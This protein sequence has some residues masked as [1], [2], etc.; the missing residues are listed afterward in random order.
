MATLIGVV[1]QVIGEV[2]AVAGDGSR[3]PLT[4][5]DRVYAGEQL[6]TGATGAVAVTM[7]NGQQ[8]TLGRDS[9]L[10]LSEQLLA[11]SADGNT[12]APQSAADAPSAADLSDVEQ[13]QAA[14]EAGVDP[15]IEGEATAA[16][17]GAGGGAGGAGG[18]G[19][20]FVLLDEVGGALEPVIGFPTE[21]LGTGPEFPDPDPLVTDETPPAPDSTPEIEVEYQD[22]SGTVI[23]GPAVVD[24]EALG[25]GSN[26]GSNAEQASGTLIINS[27]D[28]VSAVEIQD[29]NGVW[30]DVTAGGVVQG[31]YG[32]LTVDAAGN[33]T[34]TLTDNTLDHS[35]P[36]AT[37]AADQVG[38]S[39]L[40]RMF[41]LDGDVSPTVSLDVLVNDD[42]PGAGLSE[43]AP[44]LGSA[45][46]D[47]S[48]PAF[49]GVGGDGVAS[50]VLSAA[51]VQAQ[52]DSAYGADGPGTTAYSLVLNGDD[53]PS[54]LFA[55]DAGAPGG[56]GAEIVLNQVGNV[57]TGSAGGVDYFTLTIDPAT[58]E[59][60]LQLLDNIWHADTT[61]HDDAQT[62]LL[63]AG[64]LQLVQTVI[65]GDGDRASV[66]IDLGAVGAFRFEDDGPTLTV[67]A[68][69]SQAEQA[70]LAVRVDETE[71]ADR[72]APGET[73][74]GN[75]DGD[76]PG[77]GR[78]TTTV[79]G[80]LVNLFAALGGDH[81]SDGPGSD[82]GTFSFVG[83]PAGGTLATNLQAIDGGAIS[84]VQSSA[85]LL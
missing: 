71:G 42:G 78:A 20:S 29:V 11:Q 54:G 53:V 45:T 76:N 1:S 6:V 69:V 13:L 43:E 66:A 22:F 79:D 65:D 5:G 46:V 72:A 30:I 44:S 27:P 14:I 9:N 50:A 24:E 83:F 62:L 82:T 77:L 74:N 8:L 59:V 36:N 15:T 28:G 34:Y 23:V 47:E 63:D 31:Q 67:E 41:D 32:V 21:G 37:G 73:A 38:E 51:V 81:G 85:T 64:V 10:S 49:G 35:N 3:R 52:F 56:Q 75:N 40:V 60:T 16:G 4:E 57:I 58:G 26:P 18:G 84:L 7:G 17:P 25:D 68:E 19:H 80:G 61:N 33:W 39:F 55:V 12:P 2:F 48:L 70:A